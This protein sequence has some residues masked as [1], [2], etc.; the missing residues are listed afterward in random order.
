[1]SVKHGLLHNHTYH[2]LNDGAMSV[3]ALVRRA[4]DLGAPAVA[5]TDHGT[6]T[7]VFSFL[8]E[9][10]KEGIL[11]IPGVETYVL[12][13][14][15]GQAS[16]LI[17]MARNYQ[18]LKSIIKAVTESYREIEDIRSPRMKK[19]VI[20]EFFRGNEN[21][22][23]TS[24]CVGGVLSSILK[25]NEKLE[26][27]IDSL[28]K[29][30]KKYSD[31]KMSTVSKNMELA[32]HEKE[33]LE[34]LLTDRKEIEKLSKRKFA[35][36]ERTLKKL[37]GEEKE[38][39]EKK[40]R[41]EKDETAMAKKVLPEIKSRINKKRSQIRLLEK[42]IKEETISNENH[43]MLEEKIFKL[44]QKMKTEEELYEK[45]KEELRYYRNIF[46]YFYVEV[47]NHGY[48][49][50]KEI[51]QALAK[52]AREESVPVV[53]A[54]DAHMAMDSDDEFLRRQ[55]S[56]SLR[57]GKW[58]PLTDCDRELYLKSDEELEEALSAILPKDIVE[59]AMENV[60]TIVRS[61]HVEIPQEKHYP[62]FP[63]AKN[64]LFKLA[65]KGKETRFP[66]GNGW[67]E[68]YEERLDYELGIIDKLGYNDYL[69][70]VEDLLTVGRKLG[71]L[72]K[73]DLE[74]LN[75]H[76]DQMT[77]TEVH[78]FLDRHDSQVGY[79]IGP[80]RGSGAGSLV[81]YLIGIT[82]LDP[83]QYGLI[84]ERFLNPDRVSPPDI[85]SDIAKGVR[86][87]LIHYIRVK[88]G[89]DAVCGIYTKGT[90]GAKKSVDDAARMLVDRYDDTSYYTKAEK[91]KLE[92]GDELG[93]TINPGGKSCGEKLKEAF[94]EDE[95]AMEI[96]HY[97][98]LLEDTIASHG[99]HA[100]GVIIS[101]T[102]NVS[103]YVPLEYNAAKGTWASQADKVESEEWGL[104]K[105][106]ML[107][108]KNLD[109]LTDCQRRVFRRHGIS[110]D[111][112]QLP[113][114]PEV[115]SE[116][117]A[118]GNTF[119][120]FQFES[121]GMKKMLREFQPENFEDV[122]LLIACYRPGPMSFI[123]EM[124]EVK[125]GRKKASYL[126]PE[127][128]PILKDTYAAIVYQEQV[129]EIFMQ[130]A[131]YSFGQ[132]DLVRRA[133]SKKKEDVLNAERASFIHGD[134]NRGIVGCV[135]RGIS[136]EIADQLFDQMT[137]FAKYAFNRSHAAAYAKTSYLTAWSKFHYPT[138]FLTAVLNIAEKQEKVTAIIEECRRIGIKILPPDINRSGLD[139]LDVSDHE[140][141]YGLKMIRN[142]KS[143][144][145]AILIARNE[146]PFQGFKDFFLRGIDKKDVVESLI[147]SGAFDCFIE[148][149]MALI[150]G[151]EE[152]KNLAKKLG[153]KE[154]NL[155]AKKTELTKMEEEGFYK[156]DRSM[157]KKHDTLLDAIKRTQKAYH[158]LEDSFHAY[159]FQ[160]HLPESLRIK[161]KN[162][163]ASVGAYLSGHPMDE[164]PD[165]EKLGTVLIQD[166]IFHS[167]S[168]IQVMGIVENLVFR[169]RKADGA[170]MAFF[171]LSDA[172]GSIPCCCFTKA[173]SKYGE[174]LSEGEALIANGKI[175][176]DQAAVDSTQEVVKI[177]IF[178][179]K[180]IAPLKKPI[181]IS[182]PDVIIWQMELYPLL[183]KFLDGKGHPLILY[184][185][186][187]GQFREAAF[188]VSPE[189]LA[190]D[191]CEG[192][193]FL[194][195]AGTK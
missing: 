67:N 66:N 13:E 178:D 98:L 192:C 116:I 31:P 103:D 194:K 166:V 30:Q 21:V 120:V 173:F 20:E 53:A 170:P 110:I 41:K 149:R 62:V 102:E 69:C 64:Q 131:G 63:D 155:K 71:H 180:E 17:L 162:E 95:K 150:K 90:R 142:V 145:E 118:K 40:L 4:K 9:C 127:L 160:Q 83:I 141:L 56:F 60:G 82:N 193:F 57:F 135:A 55:L 6:L 185:R 47:Q 84:F 77:E 151:F 100:A 146:K 1:M 86:D 124:I 101:D 5:L 27:S 85:D 140:I 81:N 76:M 39:F 89:K 179:L 44:Q 168:K 12:N 59:E 38:A 195:N 54:N 113:F 65:V 42:R 29:R 148:N 61:V 107:G 126:T 138:E 189:I 117:F 181:I 134:S 73:D 129:M 154:R 10:K 123:P 36:K 153:E 119:G 93:T 112:D 22:I 3:T 175:L 14:V 23:A 37:E 25:Q 176:S 97:A 52:A 35:V 139:F 172:T 7:G 147:Y 114:E 72:S 128:K 159:T 46:P 48:P 164:Y 8:K 171:N 24:A 158:L 11:G 108:L 109:I 94:K 26:T 87:T 144:S 19:A 184:D 104:L 136:E 91:V 34:R 167:D 99:L 177:N 183:Q 75:M 152:M 58:N 45:A 80:G 43:R 78:T 79:T 96:L 156:T 191:L 15:T 187:F 18:G 169:N 174:L 2:S 88:Y 163:R 165:H 182:I 92:I 106:D 188:R 115:F 157:M 137:D 16:H 121:D 132:A 133:M 111:F 161:L 125:H 49:E 68:Q 143:A 190:E 51:F 74:A 50:E 28:K 105:I 130:L 70:C 186:V 122:I 32:K 33:E